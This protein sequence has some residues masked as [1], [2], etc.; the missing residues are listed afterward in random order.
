MLYS[1]LLAGGLP[2]SPLAP[3]AVDAYA[4]QH[5]GASGP[6]STQSVWVHLIA[7]HLMLEGGWSVAQAVRIRAVAADASAG[8][9]WLTPPASMG[10]TTIVDVSAAAPD[11]RADVV[12]RWVRD[13][14]T[15]WSPHHP[16]VRAR[17]AGLFR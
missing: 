15:A 17:A 1:E 13:A 10:P 11:A 12:D 8:V 14:Y 16:A 7:L 2:T 4:I 5:P 3:L 9:A 6:Q